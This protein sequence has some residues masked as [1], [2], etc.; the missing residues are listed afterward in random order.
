MWLNVILAKLHPKQYRPAVSVTTAHSCCRAAQKVAGLQDFT[1][2][3]FLR[4]N[5]QFCVFATAK[6]LVLCS[7]SSNAFS[8]QYLH[9]Q[10]HK[11]FKSYIYICYSPA[12]GRFVLGKTVPSVLDTTLGLR[13]RA[14]SLQFFPIR[15]DLVLVNNIFIFF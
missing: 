12:L 3:M 4:L 10:I 11:I 13:P 6:P 2:L 9:N 7:E 14:V 8:R 5:V 15:T 1:G